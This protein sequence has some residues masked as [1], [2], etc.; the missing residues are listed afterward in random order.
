MDFFSSIEDIGPDLFN[1]ISSPKVK[2]KPIGRPRMRLMTMSLR[3]VPPDTIT[4]KK[5]KLII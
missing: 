3:E 2:I 1:F 5:V 4:A